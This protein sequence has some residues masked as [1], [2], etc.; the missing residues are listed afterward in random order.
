MAVN[1]GGGGGGGVHP[2]VLAAISANSD[3]IAQNMM[4][5]NT[6][7]VKVDVVFDKS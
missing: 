4:S 1:A 3:K 6:N 5:I 2:V 7:G